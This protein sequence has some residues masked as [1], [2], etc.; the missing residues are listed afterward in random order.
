[1][2]GAQAAESRGPR[3]ADVA[4]QVERGGRLPGQSGG[5]AHGVHGLPPRAWRCL[6][7]TNAIE[8]IVG[9]FRRRT[10]TPGA[11]PTPEAI[12]IVLWGTL[13]TGGI[14]LRKVHGYQTMTDTTRRQAA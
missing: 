14:R 6:Q 4:D 9:E 7:T 10:K 2:P 5:G 12:V 3:P 13:A 8:R 1:M 11:L